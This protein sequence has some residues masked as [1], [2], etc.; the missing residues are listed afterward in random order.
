LF[1]R[2][3]R[4]NTRCLAG[5]IAALLPACLFAQ[6]LPP[7]W[8]SKPAGDSGA[9][10]FVPTDLQPGEAVAIVYYPAANFAAQSIDA[11][12]QDALGRDAP[13][14]GGAWQGAPNIKREAQGVVSATRAYRDAAGNQGFAVYMAVSKDQRT[15]R[16][17]RWTASSEQ[18]GKRY[19]DAARF[20]MQQIAT[21]D[22]PSAARSTQAGDTAKPPTAQKSIQPYQW[23]NAPGK[24]LQAAQIEAVVYGWRQVFEIGGL[25]MRENAYLLLKDGAVH[26]G[27]PVPP[28]DM[29]IAASRRQEPA[30]W[31]RWQR[32]G[33]GYAFAWP[34]QPGEFKAVQGGPM[35]AV[36]AGVLLDGEWTAASSYEI[37]G[38]GGAWSK[39]G[40]RLTRDGRFE[41]FRFGG[42]GA[43][44]AGS[45]MDVVTSSVW[46]DK[47]AVTAASAPNVTVRNS[48]QNGPRG[49]LTGRYEIDGYAITLR[50]DDGL[51]V[52]LPFFTEGEQHKEIWFEGA[53]LVR[54]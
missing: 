7:D 47:G 41:K 16:L 30:K 29:D 49:D 51:V 15:V 1:R 2:R 22:Q 33:K 11:W 10:I 44:G 6:A 28:Q 8:V 25:Q 48:K 46:D 42:A 17:G 31:G 26:N 40:L 45:G 18:A 32:S 4:A 53:L 27:L 35:Q 52:R 50:Q 34:D 12:V 19:T 39:W 23:V 13:M 21:T 37:P 20:L 38:G 24:G 3:L 36:R 5:V 43:G 14:P 9:Q 54:K